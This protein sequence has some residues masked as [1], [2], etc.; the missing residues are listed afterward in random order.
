MF[1]ASHSRDLT[2]VDIVGLLC[3]IGVLNL[4]PGTR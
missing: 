2:D 4:R 3:G 1:R